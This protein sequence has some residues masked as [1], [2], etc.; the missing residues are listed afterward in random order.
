M[1][2]YLNWI[3]KVYEMMIK[4]KTVNIL[5]GWLA[6]PK[7]PA[8]GGIHCADQAGRHHHPHG[9]QHHCHCHHCCCCYPQH[10]HHDDDDGG[11]MWQDLWSEPNLFSRG[12]LRLFSVP[13][14][15][16]PFLRLFWDQGWGQN[17]CVKKCSQFSYVLR[18]KRSQMQFSQRVK[19]LLFWLGKS[20][21]IIRISRQEAVTYSHILFLPPLSIVWVLE[22]CNFHFV[23]TLAQISIPILIA[24]NWHHPPLTHQSFKIIRLIQ[25]GNNLQCNDLEQSFKEEE[26]KYFEIW[27]GQW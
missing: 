1:L 7:P 2:E 15:G 4:Q 21:L 11:S 26:E 23:L 22:P 8:S 19:K 18:G 17:P 27:F 6:P 16:R 12:T 25:S 20:S 3:F 14:I 10:C 5:K 24:S 13:N 9:C